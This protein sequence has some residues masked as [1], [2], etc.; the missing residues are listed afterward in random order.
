MLNVNYSINEENNNKIINILISIKAEQSKDSQNL[1]PLYN[2]FQL[3]LTEII[4]WILESLTCL[5]QVDCVLDMIIDNLQREKNTVL[6]KKKKALYRF[7]ILKCR[8]HEEC[9]DYLLYILS[10][11]SKDNH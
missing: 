3:K 7:E 6:H 1:H 11:I 10:T 8:L 2:E 4:D 5:T 9:I